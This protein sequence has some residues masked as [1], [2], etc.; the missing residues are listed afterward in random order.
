[1]ARQQFAIIGLGRFGISVGLKL[2]ESG[3]DVLVIDN[4]E[5]KVQEVEH[6]FTH[7]VVADATDEK[8]LTSLGIRNF[9]C[10]IVAIGSDIQSSILSTMLLS[11]LGVERIIAKAINERHGQVLDRIGVDWIVYPEKDMGER[12]AN[13][14]LSPNVLNY[15]ELSKEH[16]IEEM[17]LPA[18]M[19]GKTLKELNLRAKYKVNVIAIVRD[20]EAVVSLNPD[21]ALEQDDLLIV[22]GN[23]KDLIKFSNL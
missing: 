10:V 2:V 21:E 12:V 8:A 17:R 1:M 18:N 23:R 6:Y 20:G 19:E 4:S 7:A 11:N 5:D 9:D 3:Q 22:I 15:I 16:N 13:Q 14:I